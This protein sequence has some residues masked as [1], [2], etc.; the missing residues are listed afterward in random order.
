MTD[1]HPSATMTAAVSAALADPGPDDG[2]LLTSIVRLTRTIFE[3]GACSLLLL[4]GDTGELVF[5]AVAGD[6]EEFL[7][8]ARF[9]ADRGV[10]G[11]VLASG[12]P[13]AIDDL[14][15]T[16]MFARD[17]AERT[18]YVPGAIM[19][20]P[21]VYDGSALGVLEV[22]DPQ[23]RHGSHI[24]DLD[25]LLI[26]GEQAGISLRCLARARS[27]QHA[28]AHGGADYE[29]LA[30]LVQLIERAQPDLRAAG[31]RLVES[32]YDMLRS[33]LVS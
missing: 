18:G 30:A 16:D 14:G 20:V 33:S 25:L 27:A 12:E 5:E 6:G 2:A 21:V 22:L 23:S 10:A 9:P 28:L 32:L 29:G 8:G 1:L 4:D 17:L 26:V 15:D 3:A 7:V 19:V 13:V 31:M 24:A 11:W